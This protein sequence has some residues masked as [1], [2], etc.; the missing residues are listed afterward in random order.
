MPYLLSTKTIVMIAIWRQTRILGGLCGWSVPIGRRPSGVPDRC[1]AVITSW[2][3]RLG[4]QTKFEHEFENVCRCITNARCVMVNHL[5]ERP[6]TP[7]FCSRD[8]LGLRPE[9][10]RTKLGSGI[11]VSLWLNLR[12][13]LCRITWAMLETGFSI[14][15][16]WL[17]LRWSLSWYGGITR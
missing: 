17:E 13:N 5:L 6:T 4:R 16:D 3:D 8:R 2:S 7:P 10:A 12:W 11:A 15:K 14:A 1:C 9:C